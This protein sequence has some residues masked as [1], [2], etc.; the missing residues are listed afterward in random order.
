VSFL[1]DLQEFDTP[2]AALVHVGVKGMKWGV[3]K[4]GPPSSK[5]VTAKKVGK[6]VAKGA[7]YAL[8]LG[9]AAFVVHQLAKSGSTPVSSISPAHVDAAVKATQEAFLASVKPELHPQ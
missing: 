7:G 5:A 8:T 9:G 6:N 1:N 4:S 2:E 3:R